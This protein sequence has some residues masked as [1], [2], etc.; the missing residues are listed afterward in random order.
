MAKL[1]P[2]KKLSLAVRKEGTVCPPLLP[3]YGADVV[4]IVREDYESKKPDLEKKL[5]EILGQD[6]KV[7]VDPLALWPYA[8][9]MGGRGFGTT[10]QLCVPIHCVTVLIET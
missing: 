4:T 1:P 10:L 8:E 7:D 6:W 9:L 3:V 5:S 2:A